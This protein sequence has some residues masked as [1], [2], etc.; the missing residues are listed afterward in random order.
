[1]RKRAERLR[2][3]V[4]RQKIGENV[5]WTVNGRVCHSLTEINAELDK[6]THP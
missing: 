6:I 1:M 5:Q 4:E 3:A 2:V